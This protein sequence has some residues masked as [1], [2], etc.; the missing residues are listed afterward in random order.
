MVIEGE[1]SGVM[2][3]ACEGGAGGGRELAFGGGWGFTPLLPTREACFGDCDRAF[4]S[5]SSAHHIIAIT[6]SEQNIEPYL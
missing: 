4:T 2:W 6:F 5:K 3:L 1:G